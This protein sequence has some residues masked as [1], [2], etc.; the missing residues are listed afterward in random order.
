MS[1]LI[2]PP[3]PEWTSGGLIK[4]NGRLWRLWR[5]AAVVHWR[6]AAMTKQS[7]LTLLGN[8]VSMAS[9][10]LE[11]ATAPTRLVLL[12][13]GAPRMAVGRGMPCSRLRAARQSTTDDAATSQQRPDIQCS[14]TER[15]DGGYDD[16]SECG[17][18]VSAPID[19]LLFTDA[20]WRN[21]LTYFHKGPANGL[22]RRQVETGV[23]C[24]PRFRDF[25]FI[26]FQ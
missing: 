21:R 6:C 11:P 7:R 26:G 3:K 12:D 17:K 25:P 10:R 14:I 16:E 23:C 19:P 2:S 5:P 15:S 4:T 24:V 1:N 18:P 20:Q 8:R 22:L 9:P 13:T